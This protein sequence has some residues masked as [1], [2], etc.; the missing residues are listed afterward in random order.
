VLLSQQ[1]KYSLGECLYCHR[2]V[3]GHLIGHC[4]VV[5]TGEIVDVDE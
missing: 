1:S 5:A 2:L 3:V 4:L